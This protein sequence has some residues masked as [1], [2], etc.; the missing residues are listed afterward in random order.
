MKRNSR[1]IVLTAAAIAMFLLATWR[2]QA[3]M[4]LGRRPNPDDY[5]TF[6]LKCLSCG[7]EFEKTLGQMP[8]EAHGMI[9]NTA[10]VRV[11]C[12]QCGAKEGA[13]MQK[14]LHCG[15]LYVSAWTRGMLPGHAR[16]ICPRCGT[17]VTD[18]TQGPVGAPAGS[19][20]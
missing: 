10:L 4:R 11:E 8:A 16:D 13:V 12:P 19:K 17:D 2:V 1:N 3:W 9:V 6:H 18:L 7:H 15:K 5:V 20:R 14:C